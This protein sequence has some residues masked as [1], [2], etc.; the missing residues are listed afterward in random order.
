M[1]IE[2]QKNDKKRLFD[3]ASVVIILTL[4]VPA[5]L[6]SIFQAF[7]GVVDM[8]FVGRISVEA[9]AGVGATNMLMNIYIAFFTAVGIGTTAVVARSVGSGDIKKANIAVKQSILIALYISVTIGIITA[10]FGKQI[11]TI[12]GA[13]EKV[14]ITALPY[15][16][17]VAVPSVFLALMTVLSSALRGSGDTKTPMQATIIA[18]IINAILGY[19][20]IF[21]VFGIPG[22]GIIGAGIATT[23]SR[24]ISTGILFYKL[25][26]EKTKL[27]VRLFEK[28][29]IDKEI[30]KSVTKIGIPAAIERLI[31]RFGQLIYGSM[32][33]WIGTQ[34]Y[35]AFNIAGTIDMFAYLP[36]F[37][38]AAAAATLVGQNLGAEKPEDARRLGLM[39]NYVSLV[40]M[41][42]MGILI[43]IF[44]PILAGVFTKDAEV[45]KQTTLILRITGFIQPFSSI[46]IIL[47]A[48]LQ[49]AGDTKFPMY[50]TFF[51]IWVIRIIGVYVLGIVLRMGLLGV[52]LAVSLDLTLRAIILT[53]RFNKGKWQQIKI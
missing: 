35:A 33:I 40:F 7:I 30:F 41:S 51:G 37:G 22:L 19:V 43:M 21:G 11:L 48:A 6:E 27:S 12:L 46:T 3:K 8:Y 4:A 52:C 23:T 28:W 5:M 18:N 47:T 34:A 31:M 24:I 39:C 20:L 32:I 29:H 38:F 50:S 25:N 44:A 16:M 53:I 2:K 14:V 36:G 42:I 9:I 15:F 45:I 10:L 26:S 1:F 17:A 49:G 13:E